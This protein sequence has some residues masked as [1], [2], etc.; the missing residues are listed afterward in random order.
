MN[1]LNKTIR[2]MKKFYE[3]PAVEMN[4]IQ[5]VALMAVSAPLSEDEAAGDSPVEVNIDNIWSED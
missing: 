5:M 4:E 2:T 3:A 1:P